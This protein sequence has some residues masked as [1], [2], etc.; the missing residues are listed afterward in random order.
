MVS[1]MQ[2]V[3]IF[4]VFFDSLVESVTEIEIQRGISKRKSAAG[5]CSCFWGG[6]KVL[7][8]NSVPLSNFVVFSMR[9]SDEFLSLGTTKFGGRLWGKAWDDYWTILATS[10]HFLLL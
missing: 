3:L 1:L 7:M 9:W 10:D 5:N 4:W 8:N 6:T 2:V